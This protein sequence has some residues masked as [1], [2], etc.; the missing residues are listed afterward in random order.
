MISVRALSSADAQASWQLGRLAFG[1]PAQPPADRPFPMPGARSLGAFEGERLVGKAVGLE[2]EYFYG[3]RAVPAV[4]VAGVAVAPEYRGRRV[5]RELLGALLADLR[6]AAAIAALFPTT[7]IPYRRLGWELVGTLRWTAVPTTAL[8]TTAPDDARVRP[9]EVRDVPA[10]L[11]LYTDAAAAGTGMLTRR[12]ALF[13]TTPEALLACHDGYSVAEQNGVVVGCCSW[14]RSEGYDAAAHLAVPDLF[15]R[16]PEGLAALLAMLGSWRSVAPT[17]HL[18]LR[19]DDPVYLATAL[20]GARTLSEQPWMLR[21]VDAPAA[22]AARGWPPHLRGAVDL[23]LEDDLCPWNAG[24]HRLVLDG[25]AGT[26]EPGGTGA[27]RVDPG[28]LA[29]LYAGAVTPATLRGLDRLAGGDAHTDA[30]LAA[31]GAGPTPALLDYF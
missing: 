10:I 2:H 9:A 20:L 18:R 23:H 24:P 26:L 19:P 4:G 8:A 5:L 31:S 30:F 16:A 22:V 27:V 12:G 1:A 15:A 13:Q 29:T 17:L 11:E 25:G 3:G 28:A 6:P 7:P 14:D 21:L